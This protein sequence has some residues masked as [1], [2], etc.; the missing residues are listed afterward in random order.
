MSIL[1]DKIFEKY[2]KIR[3]DEQRVELRPTFESIKDFMFFWFTQARKEGFNVTSI[4]KKWKE[5]EVDMDDISF[6]SYN[7]K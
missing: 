3:L 1:N 4:E 5:I 7:K 6:E 2:K